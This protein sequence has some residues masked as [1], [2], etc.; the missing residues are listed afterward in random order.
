MS[1]LYAPLAAGAEDDGL[2]PLLPEEL[3]VSTVAARAVGTGHHMLKVEGYSRLKR[4]HGDNGRSLQSDEFRAGGHTWKILCYLD[5]APKKDA[6]FISLYLA[7]AGSVDVHAEVEFELVDHRGTPL[8]WWW[9]PYRMRMPANPFRAG[10]SWGIA[11]FISAEALER[12]RFL[13]G[14]CFAVRCKV[15][16]V[17]ERGAAA[18]EEV[19]AEDMERMG[20]VCLCKDGSCNKLHR[21]RPAETFT[22]AFDRLCLSIR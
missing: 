11:K 15:T 10:K 20:M 6:G 7:T 4:M 13:R 1:P 12:S 16:V 9:R 8:A 2:S 3:T 5:G 14:D 18:A 21:A 22:E 17:E 19:Q